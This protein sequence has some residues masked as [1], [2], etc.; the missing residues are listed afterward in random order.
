MTRRIR[1]Q[2]NSV[3]R[4]LFAVFFRLRARLN[5]IVELKVAGPPNRHAAHA[6][7]LSQLLIN[8]KGVA[9]IEA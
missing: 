7:S 1:L 2:T 4:S 6:I 8:P 3:I 5:F 9:G